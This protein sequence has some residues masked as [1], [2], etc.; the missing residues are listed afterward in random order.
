MR[1]SVEGGGPVGVAEVVEHVLDWGGS[2][3]G[4]GES[5]DGFFG[6]KIYGG[7]F[8][9]RLRC[10]ASEGAEEEEL[11]GVEGIRRVIVEVVVVDGG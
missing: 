1:W 7:G 9:A 8:E 11:V 4:E 3:A 5:R 2:N 6:E 10:A